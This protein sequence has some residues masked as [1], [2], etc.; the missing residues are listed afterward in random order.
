[1]FRKLILTTVALS[2]GAISANASTLYS[3]NFNA[4]AQSLNS[5]P[6]GWAVSNGTVD[7]I[8][9]G[10]FD[11]YPGNGNYI[12]MDGS[13]GDAGRIDTLATFNLIAGQTYSIKFD[14]GKNNTGAETLQVG[15]GSSLLQT[16]VL[17]AGAVPSL[18]QQ[19]VTFVALANETGATLHFEALGNDNQ[20]PVI[21]NVSLSSASVPVPA[22]LPLMGAGL[23]LMG[24]LRR[25]KHKQLAA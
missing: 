21:D 15:L 1:M 10:F 14:L 12:D 9:T 25:R 2:A 5:T 24:F 11:F 4:S 18:L 13:T 8:G 16:I 23:G 7:T 3:D 19:V 20:G 6:T 22:A 17:A